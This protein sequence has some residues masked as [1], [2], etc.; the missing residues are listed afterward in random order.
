MEHP[1]GFELRN[2][3]LTIA[4][5]REL[6]RGPQPNPRW[7]ATSPIVSAPLLRT[8]SATWPKALMDS[9]GGLNTTINELF[10]LMIDGSLS[11]VYGIKQLKPSYLDPVTRE[12]VSKGIPAGMTLLLNDTAPVGAKALERVDSGE[13][14]RDVL[15]FFNIVSQL[16]AESTLSNEI[17]L[18]SLPQKQVRATEVVQSG[19]AI[20]GVFD[21]IT[22]DFEDISVERVAE[23]SWFD[24]LQNVE[25]F[26]KD[27]LA[28]MIGE[29]GV[30]ELNS[31]SP[32]QRFARAANGFKFH[33]KGL[34]TITAR[35]R[36]FQKLV[37]FLSVVGGNE[38]M[39]REFSLRFSMPKLL[40]KFMRSLEIDSEEIELDEE[41]IK[42]RQEM[43][44]IEA[45]ARGGAQNAEAPGPGRRAEE[46]SQP[47]EQ[48]VP[49]GTE[50]G[51]GGKRS[52]G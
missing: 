23:E 29:E 38:P 51:S 24:I 41:E 3:L 7:S 47:N 36:D 32:K 40:D 49:E 42:F 22:A 18:G 45:Q 13:V 35:I 46:P 17:R 10:N 44:R 14:P 28:R 5:E 37:Q 34:R 16:H 21:A 52:M 8:P 26:P 2:V 48:A 11:A 1:D 20:S 12:E 33:G 25:K 6:I 19:Q 15:S 9:A 31:L 27:D 43:E 50:A 4:N 30:A 39:M